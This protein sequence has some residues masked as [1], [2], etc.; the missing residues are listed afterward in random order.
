MKAANCQ[1]CLCPGAGH[2]RCPSPQVWHS[3]RATKASGAKQSCSNIRAPSGARTPVHSLSKAAQQSLTATR[4]CCS[5][6]PVPLPHGAAHRESFL[7]LLI[8]D[9]IQHG[10]GSKQG[11]ALQ[12]WGG[13]RK[14]SARSKQEPW[15]IKHMPGSHASPSQGSV[16]SWLNHP[17]QL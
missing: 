2:R 17:G 4:A 14:H 6:W 13:N 11:S 5:L 9:W 10:R 7:F 1:L 15:G 16:L 3:D 8:Q 12:L